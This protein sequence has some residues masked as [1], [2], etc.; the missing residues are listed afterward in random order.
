MQIILTVHTF[1]PRSAGGTEVYALALARQLDRQG[2]RVHIVTCDSNTEG[3]APEV[4]SRS[5][6]WQGFQVERLSFNLLR[7]P[8]PVRYDYDNQ[9]VA[10]FLGALYR[11]ERPDLVHVCHPGNLS[12]A[13]I[14]AA[15]E[16]NIPTVLTATDFWTICPTSQLLRHDRVLCSGP[17]DP[18]HCLVCTVRQRASAA[19][20]RRWIDPVP[21]PLLRWGMRLARQPWASHSSRYARM[22]RALA[23]RPGWIRTVLASTGRIISPSRFLRDRLVDNGVPADRITVSAHGIET[24]WL[25]PKPGY[26]LPAGPVRFATVGQLS[27]HKGVHLAV[28]AFGKLDRPAGAVLTLYGDNRQDPD[29]WRELQGLM[30][31]TPLVEF[32]GSFPHRDLARVLSDVDVLLMPSLWYEN[33]PTIMYEAFATQTPAIATSIGG[34]AELIADSDGGWTFPRGDVEALASRMQGLIDDS[35]ELDRARRR[36]RPVRTIQEHVTDVLSIYR[37]L[38]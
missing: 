28:Q 35:A 5:D 4:T 30:H 32:G 1:F 29:Y 14:T 12:M 31:R 9:H 18:A 37:E 11:R 27:W 6:S 2:H 25:E 10:R 7:S 26:K 36:I 15:S 38:I 24:D 21:I 8:N 33:T 19:R 22:A 20:I 13:V 17:R 34:M 16:S 23:E 3:D